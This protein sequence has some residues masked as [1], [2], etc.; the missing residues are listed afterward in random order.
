M[1]KQIGF[2]P[3]YA[4]STVMPVLSESPSYECYSIPC[5]EGQ[6]YHIKANFNIGYATFV[7]ADSD[8]GII[9]V[10]KVGS[11]NNPQI[12]TIFR[13]PVGATRLYV[14]SLANESLIERGI[15]NNILQ[16]NNSIIEKSIADKANI[17][18]IPNLLSSYMTNGLIEGFNYSGHADVSSDNKIIIHIP[19]PVTETTILRF[20]SGFRVE[21]DKV[22][23]MYVHDITPT[24]NINLYLYKG[25]NSRYSL[26]VLTQEK[27]YSHQFELVSSDTIVSFT[28]VEDEV[29]YLS[30][31]LGKGDVVG[32]TEFYP[33]LFEG[34][35]NI[36]EILQFATKKELNQIESALSEK[37][38]NNTVNITRKV[39]LPS[40]GFGVAGKVLST[41]GNNSTSWIDIS[42]PEGD[43]QEAVKQY[44]SNH[45]ELITTVDYTITEK[46]FDSVEQMKKD[47]TLVSGYKVKTMGYYTGSQLGAARYIITDTPNSIAVRNIKLNNGLYAILEIENN[48]YNLSQLGLVGDKRP[49]S[50]DEGIDS[51]LTIGEVFNTVTQ[52]VLDDL[53]SYYEKFNVSY[54][55]LSFAESFAIQYLIWKSRPLLTIVIDGRYYFIDNTIVLENSVTIKGLIHKAT[56]Y[57]RMAY[58]NVNLTGSTLIMRKHDAPLFTTR[59]SFMDTKDVTS[60]YDV[61]LEHFG[62][63][64]TTINEGDFLLANFISRFTLDNITTY[65]FKNAINK[66][67][68]LIWMKVYDCHFKHCTRNGLYLS[69][70]LPSPSD[71][72]TTQLNQIIIRSTEIELVNSV[73]DRD[74][75]KESGNCIVMSGSGVIIDACDLESANVAVYIENAHTEGCV[76]NAPYSEGVVCAQVYHYPDNTNNKAFTYINGFSKDLS[77]DKKV[78]KALNAVV[79]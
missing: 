66:Q 51:P 39:P 8:N 52:P 24:R 38:N 9:L 22:Y 33:Y 44:L 14:N 26:N 56:D 62:A 53:N 48:T 30:T 67:S 37:I 58:N 1:E 77:D 34:E 4:N 50:I 55:M 78:I 3:V 10:G 71:A 18:N 17:K 47:N 59:P 36:D 76:I 12:D 13:V 21:K 31:I 74:P 68:E 79:A 32:N 40:D 65:G 5:S 49:S 54:N 20:S 43:I 45:P 64:A 72:E 73:I 46:I 70:L 15:P 69:T 16:Q 41:N 7:F 29:V 60:T 23:T 57:V 35:F 25:R 42:T 28:S 27:P 6:I 61:N 11:P 75:K 19:V 2:Y 63:L